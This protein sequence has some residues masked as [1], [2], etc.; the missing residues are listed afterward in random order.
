[1]GTVILTFVFAALTFG[2]QELG[3]NRE[4]KRQQIDKIRKEK[5]EMMQYLCE[6]KDICEPEVNYLM[7]T[8]PKPPAPTSKEENL[9]NG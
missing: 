5:I 2:G 9:P 3:K 4:W 8:D 6:R 1:M 7:I